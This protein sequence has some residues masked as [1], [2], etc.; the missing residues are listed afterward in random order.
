MVDGDKLG[1]AGF[2]YIGTPYT[3]M[4]C[5]KFVEQCLKDCG[6]NKDL[7]GSNAWFRE[8]Y[9]NG[10][11]TTPEKCVDELG[12]VPKGAF[13][14]ILEHDG[15]EPEKYKPDG[16]GNA[17]HIGLVTGKGEGAIHSSKSKGGVCESK[18]K[19]K[20]INGGWNRVGLWEQVVYNYGEDTKPEPDPGPE[21]EPTPTPDPEPTENFAEVYA[22]N[23]KPVKMRSQPSTNCNLYEY[24]PCGT[25]VII[26]K[27]KGEWSAIRLEANRKKCGYMMTKFLRPLDTP[28]LDP[29]PEPEPEPEPTPTQKT[30]YYTVTIRHLTVYDA[31]ALKARYDGAVTVRKED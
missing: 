7:A 18:F 14:F 30:D 24:I 5:Q 12:T 20:T 29:E 15:G 27:D 17:S 2:K 25:I 9:N 3:T 28:Q 8:V 23:G 26:E 4:D 22:E 1:D 10:L 21:P 31:E 16:L 6:C 13:L 19:N 11:I